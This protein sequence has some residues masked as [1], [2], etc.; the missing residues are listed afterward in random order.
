M[1]YDYLISW[2]YWAIWVALV[3][4]IWIP[5]WLVRERYYRKCRQSEHFSLGE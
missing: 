1:W 3:A 4:A 5:I 2:Q